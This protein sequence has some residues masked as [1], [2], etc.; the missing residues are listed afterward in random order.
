MLE[1]TVQWR[2]GAQ[3][4][5]VIVELARQRVGVHLTRG[6]ARADAR[7]RVGRL[8]ALGRASPVGRSDG[9]R[10]NALS[11]CLTGAASA[12]AIT[13]GPYHT[14][15]KADSTQSQGESPPILFS[16][17]QSRPRVHVSK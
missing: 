4:K 8:P 13:S 12:A 2:G 3:R 6:P 7:G 15:N 16:A 17:T 1:E 5:K 14:D 11:V 9:S 10:D